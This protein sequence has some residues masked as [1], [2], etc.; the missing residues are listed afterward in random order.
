M[1]VA[2]HW[3]TF[4]HAAWLGWQ[5]ES[6]WTRPWLFVI[7]SIIRP[8]AATLI[9][10]LMFVIVK[11]D[12]ASDPALFAYVYL[13]SAFY[14]FV[15]NVLFGITYVIHEDREHYQTLKQLYIAPISFFVYISG[16]AATKVLLTAVSVVI[17]LAFG[18]VVLGLPLDLWVINWPLLIAAMLIGLL[19]VAAIGFA[20]AGVS[21]LTAKHSAGINEGIGG[22]FYL[23]CGVVF[24][25]SVLPEWGQA[26]GRLIPI[27]YWLDLVR[28]SLYPG[29]AIQE[30]SGLQ[31]Y[32]DQ[33]M[34]LLL[35]GSTLLFLLLSLGIFRY[36]DRVARKKGKVD[37]ITTY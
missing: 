31:G 20:L 13:G 6:N 22:A 36:A 8:I 12:V 28:R 1:A 7:Y 14:M 34:L 3:R 16:R 27:T 21:M 30:L 24:P 5:M 19:C 33:A 23:F 18:V 35:G 29:Q 4:K 9:L 2:A 11:Q 25:L 10:V 32:S 15:A 37:M 26:I 17:S